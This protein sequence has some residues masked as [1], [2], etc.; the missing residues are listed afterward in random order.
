MKSLFARP[1]CRWAYFERVL[2]ILQFLIPGTD[3]SLRLVLYVMGTEFVFSSSMTLYTFYNK[4]HI[5]LL[6][7]IH[8]QTGVDWCRL[9]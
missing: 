2:K 1:Q 7:S 6:L 5:Y 9:L 4:S 8:P 3:T